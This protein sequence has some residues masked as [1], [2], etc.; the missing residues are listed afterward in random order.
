[1][2]VIAIIAI[3]AGILIPNFVKARDD[4]RFEASHET[5]K[6]IAVA[7]GM[8]AADND[9]W[10]PIRL[11]KLTPAYLKTVP[12]CPYTNGSYSY[13]PILVDNKGKSTGY[14]FYSA[15]NLG[16]FSQRKGKFIQFWSGED[17]SSCVNVK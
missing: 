13:G 11:D 10:Y 14:I 12:T 7:L 6:N 5:A 2:I 4:E 3:L 9:G 17:R 15:R 8:Y 16:D 1:M